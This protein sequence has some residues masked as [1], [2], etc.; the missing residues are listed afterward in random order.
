[1]LYFFPR[2]VLD[3]IWNLIV[4]VS[5]G[6]PLYS[7]MKILFRNKAPDAINISNILNHKDVKGT[8]PPY[9]KKSESSSNFLFICHQLQRK[10][11]ITGM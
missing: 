5:K 1:M 3:E 2:D 6:F 4:S 7:F 8:I 11:L 10:S 9:L